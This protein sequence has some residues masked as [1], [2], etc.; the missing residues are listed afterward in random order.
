L[1][2]SEGSPIAEPW[3]NFSSLRL[4]RFRSRYQLEQEIRLHFACAS[5]YERQVKRWKPSGTI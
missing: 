4:T 2:S 1:P 3:K 5:P